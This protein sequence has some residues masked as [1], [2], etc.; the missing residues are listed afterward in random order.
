MNKKHVAALAITTFLAINGAATAQ[1]SVRPDLGLSPMSQQNAIRTAQE[2][3]DISSFSRQGLIEQLEY[4]DFS[5]ADATFAV[6]SIVVDWNA[7]AAKTAQDYLDQSGFSRG[8]LLEQLE[9]E[10]FTPA[11]AQYGVAA[12]GY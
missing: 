9:Y 10:G 4:E 7:Q 8:S 5:T 3:L 2:Y 6:D 12:A 11:Q 1:A